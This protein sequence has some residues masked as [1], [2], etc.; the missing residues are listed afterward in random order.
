MQHLNEYDEVAG[1]SN[2]HEEEDDADEGY[3]SNAPRTPYY[4]TQVPAKVAAYRSPEQTQ[5][6]LQGGA[7][8]ETNDYFVLLESSLLEAVSQAPG[9]RLD[10]PSRRTDQAT[11]GQT[12]T[13]P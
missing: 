3:D 7:S 6:A 13:R 2:V 11:R 10:T 5:E 9:A 4:C 12:R 8:V 1:G